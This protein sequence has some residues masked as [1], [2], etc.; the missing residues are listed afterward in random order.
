MIKLVIYSL[1]L[2]LWFSTFHIP[3]SHSDKAVVRAVLFYSSSCGHCYYVITE[4]LPPLSERFGEQLQIVG[5]D[6]SQQGGQVLF[7]AALE[8]F[9]VEV[10]YIPF[11]VVGENYLV[12]SADIPEKFPGLIEQYLAQGGVDWPD[13]PGLVEALSYAQTAV[14]PAA[15]PT[16]PAPTLQPT[17]MPASS[18]I[19][20]P[21]SKT[22]PTII[23][24]LFE[25][26]VKKSG[27]SEKLALDPLG[28]TFSIIVLIA[29]VLS[30]LAVGL[31]SQR[32]PAWSLT[33]AWNWL[34]PIL[35]LI[36]LGVAGYLAHVE[37]TRVQAVCGPVGDCNTV[38]Q[39]EYA[40]LFGLVPIGILGV[41]GYVTILVAWFMGRFASQR[42]AAFASLTLL[43]LTTFG[44]LFSI[45]LTFLE[46]F[47]IGA[48][49]AWCLTS[50][51]LMT[52]LFWLSLAPGRWAFSYLMGRK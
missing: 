11:L 3:G 24:G 49:C 20:Q 5:I 23:P 30:V 36:G 15:S 42:L 35:C 40:R 21:G 8:K 12:G 9:G 39:S 18:T 22:T 32:I 19:T 13:I 26:D 43:G 14:S 6:T 31:F 45:Y 28:N 17:S 52:A 10:A 1:L 25:E 44:L 48:T 27:L 4:V 51:I 37:T 46:P 16:A 38:Q 47:V 50:A 41:A 34:I 2:P 7:R 33:H 29:M